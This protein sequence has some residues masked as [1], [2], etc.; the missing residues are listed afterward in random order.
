MKTRDPATL[1]WLLYLALDSYIKQENKRI[2]RALKDE[3]KRHVR[4]KSKDFQDKN[5]R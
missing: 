4:A 3:V 1:E 2:G 5:R